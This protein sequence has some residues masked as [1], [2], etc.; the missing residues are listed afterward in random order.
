MPNDNL[1]SNKELL[2]SADKEFENNI[3]P[4]EIE[5]FAD[6]PRNVTPEQTKPDQSKPL[7]T[8]I[9]DAETV[10]PDAESKEQKFK[11]DA[12]KIAQITKIG[13][14]IAAIVK[15]PDGGGWTEQQK[16]DLDI[17]KLVMESRAAL[18]PSLCLVSFTIT[19]MCR[20]NCMNNSGTHF[21]K[22]SS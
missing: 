14:E 9:Q 19:W 5:D 8:G 10:D 13:R 22:E 15:T 6:E 12:E 20:K 17:K 4:K 1:N 7:I 3:R 21:L 11:E 2:T 16:T 18:D